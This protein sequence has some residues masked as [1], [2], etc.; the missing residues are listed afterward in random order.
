MDGHDHHVDPVALLA[1]QQQ[2]LRKGGLSSNYPEQSRFE[3][4]SHITINKRHATKLKNS[5]SDHFSFGNSLT[6]KGKNILLLYIYTS[7]HPYSI[8][9][10]LTVADDLLKNDG[11]KFLDM[12]EKLAER[13]MQKEDISPADSNYFQD[14]EDDDDGFEDDEDEVKMSKN[15]N[16][17]P[18]YQVYSIRTL[19]QKNSA[20]KRVVV[21]F[22]YLL[23]ACLNKESWRRTVKRSLKSVSSVFWKN[24]KKKTVFVKKERPK[25]K[26]SVK[27]KKIKK[28][29][30]KIKINIIS[31]PNI[32]ARQLKKQQQEERIARE[33]QKKA[34]E[35]AI[36]LEKQKKLELERQKRE[37][38]RLKKE[39]ER[40]AK[41]EERLRKE[42]EKRRRN[43]EEKDRLA[44]AEKKRKE[45]KEQQEKL[46][47][48]K[49]QKEEAERKQAELKME[50]ERKEL[51]K[52]EAEKKEAERKELEKKEAEAAAK[53]NQ[54]ISAPPEQ[55]AQQ[56]PPELVAQQQPPMLHPPEQRQQVLMDALVGRPTGYTLPPAASNAFLSPHMLPSLLPPVGEPPM[57]GIF[58]QADPNM[59]PR[60]RASAP[61]APIGQPVG[62]RRVSSVAG[63]I[64]SPISQ[65]MTDPFT[66]IKRASTSEASP[67]SFFSNFLF[68]EPSSRGKCRIGCCENKY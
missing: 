8:G 49:L 56:P 41:E 23:L 33:A 51:E 11:K 15:K 48:E 22:K 61:I 7:I 19:E 64:G 55:H 63:P 60:H 37:Q 44:A 40:R 28:G 6:V 67:R 35:E 14:E 39:E 62:S 1:R 66:P 54:D 10:I 21:C 9:G 52:K 57:M 18:A 68:G 65:D 24:W 59:L 13:R 34:E 20:W 45:E 38:E 12:M 26:R 53:K 5:R 31:S 17:Y 58:P 3:E 50:L 46:R 32:I 2:E 30:I 16:E 29:K 36:K 43:K 4:M 27:R 42:E 25:S 47:L